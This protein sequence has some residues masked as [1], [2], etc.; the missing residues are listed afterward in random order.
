[1]LD[2]RR[3]LTLA[4][5]AAALTA[6]CDDGAGGGGLE[7]GGALLDVESEVADSLFGGAGLDAGS[8][9]ATAPEIAVLEVASEVAQ[10]TT[11]APT[12]AG[13][14]QPGCV[15]TENTQC[16]SGQCIEN[17]AAKKCAKLCAG[18]CET[19]TKCAQVAAPGG[20]IVNVCVPAYPRLCEPCNAD[21]E[22]SNVVGGADNRCVPYKDD[23]GALVGNF[24]ATPCA[25]AGDC[26]GGYACSEAQS[27]GGAKS[28]QCVAEKLQC[29]C[30]ERAVKLELKTACTQVNAAGS[31]Q[32]QR[33]CS[34][35]GLSACDAK[36]AEAEACNLKDDDCDGQTDEP[37]AGMCDD[38]E[39]CTYDN[40]IGAQCQHPP[41]TGA[42][43]DSDACT[44]NEQ[45]ANG[46]CIGDKIACDDKN[47]CT[48]DA[49]NPAVGCTATGDDSASCTDS[50]ACSVGDSCKAGVCLPGAVTVCDD[51]NGCTADS[52]DPKTGCVFAPNLAPCSDDNLCTVADVCAGA[53]IQTRAPILF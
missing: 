5:F 47:P 28:K 4:A 13:C 20:D 49:C 45:C 22:C 8:E 36:A 37:S 43:K 18:T 52:C 19:G 17:G 12:D 30:D 7:V 26:P 31:C 6:A 39:S 38:G 33:G 9:E 34:A 51:Q 46:K 53:Q 48:V 40:C 29:A 3:F 15:C 27:A 2:A 25:T 1:M 50:N 23:K 16:D 10:E 42:C 21:S 44:A 11:D 41:T 24:C 35:G 14:T 32:G